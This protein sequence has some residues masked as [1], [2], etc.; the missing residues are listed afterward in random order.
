MDYRTPIRG[1]LLDSVDCARYRQ[2]HT[3]IWASVGLCHISCLS[4]FEKE[5]TQQRPQRRREMQNSAE[6][7]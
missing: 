6:T 2:I 4:N 5:R 3:F 7:V 1:A